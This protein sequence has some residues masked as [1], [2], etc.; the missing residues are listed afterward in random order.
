VF[1]WDTAKTARNLKKH[2]VGFEEAV[3]VFADS[4][5]LDWPDL[6]HSEAE[7][8][9]KRLGKSFPGRVLLVVYTIRRV[10]DGKENVRIISARQ[11]SRKERK[12]Y[13]GRAN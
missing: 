12:A 5:A 11:A 3:T 8:R 2:G 13:A 4:E 1:S 6:L 7:P 9:S 10:K